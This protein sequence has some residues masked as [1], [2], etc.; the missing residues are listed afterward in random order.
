MLVYGPLAS[1]DLP[2]QEQLALFSEDTTEY[3]YFM[4]VELELE[5]KINIAIQPK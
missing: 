5:V 4:R 2:R 1:R 3:Y